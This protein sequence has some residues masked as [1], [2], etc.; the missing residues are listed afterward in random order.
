MP[1][2]TNYVTTKYNNLSKPSFLHLKT[3]TMPPTLQS[4]YNDKRSCSAWYL[5]PNV[6][7][8]NSSF[9][10]YHFFS[11]KK[12]TF[13]PELMF[14]LAISLSLVS[15]HSSPRKPYIPRLPMTYKLPNITWG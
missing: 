4:F 8:T 15:E 1:A 10:Y 5:P 9:Y 14:G 11:N 13:I 3:E 12:T 2:V 6:Y 7:S